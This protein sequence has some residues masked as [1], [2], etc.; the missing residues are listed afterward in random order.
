MAD[1]V[2]GCAC[3]VTS[4]PNGERSWALTCAP[5]CCNAASVGSSTVS[6]TGNV[7][8]TTFGPNANQYTV[9]LKGITTG[10]YLTVTLNNVLDSQTNT[11]NVPA[12]MGVLIG[13]VNASGLVDSGDV[14]LVR[15]QTSQTA[16]AG[17]FREDVNA[18][19]AI[20]N[21]DLALVQSHLGTALP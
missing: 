19:G 5:N 15:Q 2:P 1:N 14:F 18:D 6:G 16:S 13:D 8:G 9:N 7:S 20:D 4:G 3:T 17:N 12:T 11:G 21:F 10:Q